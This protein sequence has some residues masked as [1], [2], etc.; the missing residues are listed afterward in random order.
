M[1]PAKTPVKVIYAIYT[2]VLKIEEKF[3]Q[4]WKSGFGKE[5]QFDA[6]SKGWFIQFV[7]SQESIQ[8]SCKP[9]FSVGDKIKITFERITDA[10]PR[11]TSK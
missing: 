7:G 2:E 1:E 10:H 9:E 8:F 11:S 6:P 3:N 4:V 5:A